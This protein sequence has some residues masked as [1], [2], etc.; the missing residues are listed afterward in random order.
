MLGNRDDLDRMTAAT[1]RKQ[2]ALAR[3]LGRGVSGGADRRKF[4]ELAEQLEL[5]AAER[6][7]G[8]G[9][10]GEGVT[11][12]PPARS[13][14]PSACRDDNTLELIPELTTN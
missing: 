11:P 2:A 9:S 10:A 6:E 8:E 13:V 1:L 12:W 3:R 4:I 5:E 14:A 7:R